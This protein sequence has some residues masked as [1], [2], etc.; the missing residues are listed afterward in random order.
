[1]LLKLTYFIL[2][3]YSTAILGWGKALFLLAAGPPPTSE[4]TGIKHNTTQQWQKQKNMCT[5]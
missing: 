3:T 1:M 5:K 4:L 2:A